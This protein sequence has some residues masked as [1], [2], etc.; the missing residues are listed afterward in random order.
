MKF[1]LTSS[2]ALSSI[3]AIGLASAATL[4]VGNAAQAFT[5]GCPTSIANDVTGAVS[6]GIATANQDSVATNRPLTVNTESFFGKTDW[7]FGGKLGE[8]NYANAGKGSGQSGTFNLSSILKSPLENVMLVFKSGQN[9]TLVGYLLGQGVTSGSWSSPFDSSVF[10]VPNTRDVSHVSVYYR[11]GSSEAVPEPT[12][13]AGIA[14]AGA[15]LTAYRRRR[16]AAAK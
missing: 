10:N 3:A 5:V 4:T 16:A 6:C 11:E 9:T 8:G 1:A 7:I 12:T 14:L 13:M 15:G 2:L